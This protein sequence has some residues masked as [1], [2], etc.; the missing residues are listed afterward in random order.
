MVEDIYFVPGILL[1]DHIKLIFSGRRTL[2]AEISR[3]PTKSH[4]IEKKK[5]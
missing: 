3:P 1:N 5:I 4:Q 2:T